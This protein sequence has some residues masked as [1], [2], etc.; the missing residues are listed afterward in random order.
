MQSE[1]ELFK[2]SKDVQIIF[3]H[4]PYIF[5]NF[6]LLL[7]ITILIYMK[8]SFTIKFLLHTNTKLHEK[9]LYKIS[10][11]SISFFDATP[12]GVILNRFSNDLG[13]LDK[14]NLESVYDFL[15]L[16]SGLGLFMIYLCYIHY[17]IAI[18]CLSFTFALYQVRKFY[19]KSNIQ[20]KRLDLISK[21]PI[22]SEISSTLNGLLI[23]RV[24]KQEHR[25]IKKFLGILYKNSKAFIAYSRIYKTF[26]I[27]L[28]FFMYLLSISGLIIFVYVAYF[29]GIE[30]SIFGLALYYLISIS[31]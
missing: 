2:Q 9:M 5:Q 23:I 6:L 21:S 1:A 18:P 22:F 12:I 19:L 14:D 27:S 15:D 4:L 17:G 30:A 3:N 25:F 28:Q 7:I 29:S 11:T 16:L 10:R 24:Y 26:C 31:E 13:I 20:L 8:V